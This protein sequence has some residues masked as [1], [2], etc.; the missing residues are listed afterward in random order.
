MG[1]NILGP[2]VII[3]CVVFVPV[4]IMYAFG[5]VQYIWSISD[6]EKEQYMER[7]KARQE[8][9]AFFQAIID[10]AKKNKP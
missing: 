3:L 10:K 9:S 5:M 6:H 8:R 4:L 7:R 2:I 1:N